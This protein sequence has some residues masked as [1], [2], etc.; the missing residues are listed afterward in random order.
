MDNLAALQRQGMIGGMALW[1][2]LIGWIVIRNA[3][4]RQTSLER[5][6]LEEARMNSWR[7]ALCQ[8]LPGLGAGALASLLMG[9][10]E[11]ELD[12]S[13]AMFFSAA[14][15]ILSLFRA[16]RY[17]GYL[18]GG[19]LVHAMSYSG[20]TAYQPDAV[21]LICAVLCFCE[22]ALCLA[23]AQFNRIPVLQDAGHSRA[24]AGCVAD[25][26][27]PVPCLIG[28][29][30]GGLGPMLFITGSFYQGAL[31][32]YRGRMQV[33]GVVQAAGGLVLLLLALWLRAQPVALYGLHVALLLLVEGVQYYTAHAPVL[34]EA[35]LPPR[36]GLR[37][38]YTLEKGP[39][40][41]MGLKTGDVL[42]EV[43]GR[44]VNSERM[45][46]EILAPALPVVWARW[47]RGEREMEGEQHSYKDPYEDLGIIALP[48]QTGHFY[49]QEAG[50]GLLNAFFAW[51]N[52]RRSV[53]NRSK[54]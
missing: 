21:V 31:T 13:Q 38:L 39:A 44:A 2:A 20:A 33:R 9:W 14:A 3:W 51:L 49:R 52:Q 27:W 30:G 6:F 35:D 8:L 32:P 29:A 25:I 45:L 24:G 53:K 22:G 10:L 54:E 26:N 12:I 28:L 18:Y 19:A 23:M 37:I 11:I 46:E 15:I 40:R 5:A 16:F 41:K 7:R 47:R 42:L 34:T 1:M 4:R 48:V 36:R 50:G 43:N 17:C